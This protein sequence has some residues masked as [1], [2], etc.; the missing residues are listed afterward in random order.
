MK[1][2][3]SVPVSGRL[4]AS[5]KPTRKHHPGQPGYEFQFKIFRRGRRNIYCLTAHMWSAIKDKWIHECLS[6][7][8]KQA[9]TRVLHLKRIWYFHY[10]P[11]LPQ[12]PKT[13]F[14]KKKSDVRNAWEVATWGRG[15]MRWSNLETL[16]W[17]IQYK[18]YVEYFQSSWM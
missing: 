5:R 11:L 8:W 12:F 16:L 4:S 17:Q 1:G 7:D 2:V 14:Q 18:F 3:A 6:D 9:A 13:H 10:L 15:G